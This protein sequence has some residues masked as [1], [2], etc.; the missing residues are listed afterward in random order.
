MIIE[1]RVPP[2]KE[3]QVEQII[4]QI[5]LKKSIGINQIVKLKT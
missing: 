3:R 1:V 4:R 2:G 5:L